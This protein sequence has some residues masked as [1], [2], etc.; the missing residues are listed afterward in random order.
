MQLDW[1]KS[2]VVEICKWGYVCIYTC[3]TTCVQHVY[4]CM[5][6]IALL[7]HVYQG[8]AVILEEQIQEE[9]FLQQVKDQPAE[10]IHSLIWG[11]SA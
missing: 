8:E 11:D 3:K 10:E 6:I 2:S 7:S 9:G 5:Y 4:T 1:T